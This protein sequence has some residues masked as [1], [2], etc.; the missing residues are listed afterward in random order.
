MATVYDTH[1][2]V[3]NISMN[4]RL[5]EVLHGGDDDTVMSC[6]LQVVSLKDAPPYTALSYV[7]GD[8]PPQENILLMRRMLDRDVQLLHKKGLGSSRACIIYYDTG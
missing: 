4:I 2:L 5:I 6:K 8:R 1:P 7:W 3:S